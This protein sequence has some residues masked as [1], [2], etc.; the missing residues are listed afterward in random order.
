MYKLKTIN[1]MIGI[2]IFIFLFCFGIT[3]V[4]AKTPITQTLNLTTQ[5]TEDR[6][7]EEG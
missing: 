7:D 3:Y 2:S 5:T 1:I 4:F 6:L